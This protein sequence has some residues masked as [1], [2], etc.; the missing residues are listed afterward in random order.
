[1]TGVGNDTRRAE[2]NPHI[3][4]GLINV[5]SWKKGKFEEVIREMKENQL[6][7]LGVTQT[8]LR[9]EIN[10]SHDDF[11]FA[12][13]GRVKQTRA[14][15]GVGIIFRG[16]SWFSVDGIEIGDERGLAE[17]IAAFRI[18]PSGE[19]AGIELILVIVYMTVEGPNWPENRVKF[20]IIENLIQQYE[21]EKVVV[22]GDM[23]AHTGLLGERIN[24]NGELRY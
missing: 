16:D 23:N 24:H 10:H 14:G 1:M 22:M 9:G 21:R 17:D 3:S 5:Q 4:L 19:N 18:Y 13:K 2:T 6:D 11:H 8:T 12:G 20:Q 15:G 7:I